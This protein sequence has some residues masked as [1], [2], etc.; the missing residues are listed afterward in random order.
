MTLALTI[1]LGLVVGIFLIGGVLRVAL[2][3]S[4]RSVSSELGSWH[5]SGHHYGQEHHSNG[6]S[7]A[8]DAGGGGGD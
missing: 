8:G 6:F 7:S 2:W 4:D 3:L 5:E 1:L